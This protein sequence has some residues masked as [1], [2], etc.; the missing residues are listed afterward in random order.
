MH[1]R[2]QSIFPL[3][4]SAIVIVPAGCSSGNS[5]SNE[6]EQAV[7]K[8]L[9]EVEEGRPVALWDAMPESYQNDVDS[10]VQMFG[11]NMDAEAWAQITGLLGT[12][13]ETLS[14]KQEYFLNLPD[15]QNSSEPEIAKATLKQ[16]TRLL[17]TFLG[18]TSDLEKLKTFSGKQFL[19]TTGK[20]MVE[21]AMALQKM[22]PQTPAMKLR[23]AMVSAKVETLESTATTAKLKITSPDSQDEE[24]IDFVLHEGKWLPKDM[25][26]G[27]DEGMSQAKAAMEQLPSQVEGVKTQLMMASGA[28]NGMLAPLNAAENQEQFNKAFDGM[29]AG[30]MGMMMM[31][32]GAA[33]GGPGPGVPSLSPDGGSPGGQ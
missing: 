10:V 11:Q 32:G 30:A 27:W 25:V 13:H 4:L 15:L 21:Q 3:I 23:S 22:I 19:E 6:A 1:I 29:K 16:G 33:A 5:S 12:V 24:V 9:T 7:T 8:I 31:M 17:K 14:T 18:G 2:F 28:V 26:E 20:E